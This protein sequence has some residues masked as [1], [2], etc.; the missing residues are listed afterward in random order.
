MTDDGELDPL[1]P[2]ENEL[3]AK[4]PRESVPDPAA[5]DRVIAALRG[6]GFLRPRAPGPP[7]WALQLAA[8]V[9]VF[10]AGAFVG[11]RVAM[12]NSLERN[13]ARTDLTVAER[14]L[15]LQRAGS[16]YVTAAHG[17]AD[18]TATADSTAVEVANQVLRGAAHAVMKSNLNGTLSSS[19]VA[20]LQAPSANPRQP[21]LWY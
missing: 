14:I 21:I 8:A 1:D 2:H 7:R 13:L 12:R 9:V 16:A 19:L 17:Y 18:A 11:G 6:D 20:V 10:A 3:F 15:L 4:L 5:A